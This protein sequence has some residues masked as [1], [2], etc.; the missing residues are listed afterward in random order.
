[1]QRPQGRERVLRVIRA[2]DDWLVRSY[3]LARFGILH[4]R[5]LDEIGQYLPSRGRILDVGCG[6]GLFSL[7]YALTS[8]ELELHG[9]DLNSR[10]IGQAKAAARRLGVENVHYEVADVT[11]YAR[12]DLFD[13]VYMLDIIHH[14]PKI[15]V[16]PLVRQLA[17]AL[18]AGAR[19]VIKDV[20]RRPAYK[21]WFTHA[22]DKL[23]DRRAEVSY[24]SAEELQC[25]LAKSGFRVHRHLMVDFL[26]YPH[27]IYVCEELETPA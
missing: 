5:F 20:D 17:E 21:R 13:G 16:A 10:R 8:P 3:C 19:L 9:I 2:Y 6:F 11:Q 22:L 23:M 1:M 15:T 26:P 14:I 12:G 4:Q 24:W 7:Y 18:P 25:L 27:V